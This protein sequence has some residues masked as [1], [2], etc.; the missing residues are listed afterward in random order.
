MPSA[1]GAPP[2][3]TPGS[4]PPGPPAQDPWSQYHAQNPLTTPEFAPTYGDIPELAQAISAQM[5]EVSGAQVTGVQY[6]ALQAAETGALAAKVSPEAYDRAM[7]YRRDQT[8]GSILSSPFVQLP[9]AAGRAAF[10]GI[11]APIRL[12]AEPLTDVGKAIGGLIGL[13]ADAV[14][15]IETDPHYARPGSGALQSAGVKH[16]ALVWAARRQEEIAQERGLPSYDAANPIQ[17]AVIDGQTYKETWDAMHVFGTPGTSPIGVSEP[18][19]GFKG[20]AETTPLMF[21]LGPLAR[22]AG[23][24]ARALPAGERFA[25][26]VESYI[27]NAGMPTPTMGRAAAAAFRAGMREARAAPGSLRTMLTKGVRDFSAD[28][29]G[30]LDLNAMLGQNAENP[31]MVS[32]VQDVVPTSEGGSHILNYKLV[33]AQDLVTS[34]SPDGVANGDYPSGLQPRD[35]TRAAARLQHDSIAQNLNPAMLL[36]G[37]SITEGTPIVE[38]G[39]NVTSSGNGRVAA[40]LRAIQQ[41][42]QRYQDYRAQLEARA[43]DFG[44]T[45]E[46]VASLQH[47]VLVRERAG[48]MASQDFAAAA[49]GRATAVMSPSET[50]RLDSSRLSPGILAS[51]RVPEGAT[52][53]EALL[54]SANAPLRTALMQTIPPEERAGLMDAQGNMT[55][56]ALERLKS[57]LFASTYPGD[58]GHQLLQR[59]VESPDPGMRNVE[60]ALF[61]SLPAMSKAEGLAIT[62][63]RPGALSIGA[64]VAAAVAEMDRLDRA[65]LDVASE[66][67]QAAGGE[68]F[69]G[70]GTTAALSPEALRLLEVIGALRN[71]PRQLADF[72][73]AYADGVDRLGAQGSL[74]GAAPTKRDLIDRAF[75]EASPRSA[76]ANP[77]RWAEQNGPQTTPS[78]A[79]PGAVPG[80]APPLGTE[81]PPEGAAAAGAPAGGPV[82]GPGEPSAAIP[83]EG[84]RPG[85]PSAETPPTGQAGLPPTRAAKSTRGAASGPDDIRIQSALS[86]VPR[87]APRT[88]TP[89]SK[90]LG[91]LSQTLRRGLATPEG[92]TLTAEAIAKD[93]TVG[94]VLGKAL[95]G[96][97]LRQT[98]ANKL[99]LARAL[100]ERERAPLPARVPGHGLRAPSFQGV[101]IGRLTKAI[102]EAGYNSIQAF[103]EAVR[104]G[105]AETSGAPQGLID[106]FRRTEAEVGMLDRGVSPDVIERTLGPATPLP[107][108]AAVAPPEPA[109]APTAAEAPAPAAPAA[110][111]LS[112]RIDEAIARGFPR[113]PTAAPPVGGAATPTEALP[114]PGTAA[115][116]IDRMREAGVPESDIR[117]YVGKDNYVPPGGGGK[118][119][120]TGPEGV[121]P[122]DQT[123]GAKPPST[124]RQK[125]N[126]FIRSYSASAQ[127]GPGIVPIKIT[128]D[129]IRV[130][131]DAVTRAA[132]VLP[133]PTHVEGRTLGGYVAATRAGFDGL[134]KMMTEVR[135]AFRGLVPGFTESPERT[136]S[137]VASLNPT[138]RLISAVT[139]IPQHYFRN[140]HLYNAA[141]DAATA[142]G[143]TAEEATT[144]GQAAV[145]APTRTQFSEAEYL[146]RRS[147]MTNDNKVSVAMRDLASSLDRHGAPEAA[148]ILRVLVPF[149]RFPTNLLM[150][151]SHF[152]PVMGIVPLYRSLARVAPA[153]MGAQA[154]HAAGLMTPAEASAV[155]LRYTMGAAGTVG[156]GFAAASGNITGDGPSSTQAK[157]AQFSKGIPPNSVRI[158][159]RW[160]PNIAFGELA[161]LLNHMG[162]YADSMRSAPAG[163]QNDLGTEMTRYLVSTLP[164]SMDELHYGGRLLVISSLLQN[165][166]G[167][168][169]LIAYGLGRVIPGIGILRDIT[170]ATEDASL[171][172]PKQKIT[173]LA[174]E[175]KA[176]TDRIVATF[177]KDLRDVL[178]PS[179]ATLPRG[180][181]HSQK[182][183]IGEVL[184]VGQPGPTARPFG[185]GAPPAPAGPSIWDGVF[186]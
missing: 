91:G 182:P 15:D 100:I 86:T 174:T 153:D 121:G 168:A 129:V 134:D 4:P 20:I 155:R 137:S 27:A 96:A 82:P 66:T 85:E 185:A 89:L 62:G 77:A 170:Y 157:A 21:A 68:L 177:P 51:L 112:E 105:A 54:S 83:G 70:A 90:A 44:F 107:E 49:N 81:A 97:G 59:F 110:P 63:A 122:A 75:A 39:T 80:E 175:A 9:L 34:H 146:A 116:L 133:G 48:G 111:S 147:V 46:Q 78:A 69:P 102:Q 154:A 40:I 120:T 130:A 57:A 67:Q 3:P 71:R 163:Q 60:A 103:A 98:D 31:G 17:K 123:P 136:A 115:T 132:A 160:Y 173:D 172:F 167:G 24:A 126:D 61:R 94:P 16:Q 113:Q 150:A 6:R 171:K 36:R 13:T 84:T 125:I 152:D 14:S 166:P 139:A 28:E 23:A 7:S 176:V 53:D 169:R 108:I 148:T 72:F 149:V 5:P 119:P 32:D 131:S 104:S 43:A 156:L 93:D 1:S 95:R 124:M 106:L 118:P 162:N 145:S 88:G 47:P 158:L 183:G 165:D 161:P 29:N 87:T 65:G 79:A 92:A 35:R 33:D 30:Y 101:D 178:D 22:G 144:A 127:L 184:P 37:G 151:G 114:G 164:A 10:E 56:G 135:D 50:A 64:D 26:I 117:S 25:P 74:F 142:A 11:T 140:I 38:A 186:R 12:V 159:G 52:V 42:P 41:Y 18:V 58:A 2:A 181:P 180:F 73:N 8:I 141:A 109:A 128:T 179:L 99:A 76:E 19:P 55:R 138:G 143:K 45:P